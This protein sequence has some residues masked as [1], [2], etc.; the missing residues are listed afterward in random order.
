MIKNNLLPNIP[1]SIK[2]VLNAEQ[3]FGPNL[4]SLKGKTP[5]TTPNKIQLRESRNNFKG[6][7]TCQQHLQKT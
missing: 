2:D 4:G 3:I 7:P 6:H 5:R 1:I